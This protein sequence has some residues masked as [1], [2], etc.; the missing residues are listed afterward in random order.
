MDKKKQLGLFDSP[1]TP[2]VSDDVGSETK[3]SQTAEP[4][5]VMTSAVP[6]CPRCHRPGRKSLRVRDSYYCEMCQENGDNLYFKSDIP[7]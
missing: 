2:T 6:E 3:E 4:S 1:Q 5:A 7:F